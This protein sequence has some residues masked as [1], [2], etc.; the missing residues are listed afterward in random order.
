MGRGPGSRWRAA[1]G[2][3]L[4]LVLMAGCSSAG[5]PDTS[6]DEVATTT[7]ARAEAM[8]VDD[9]L[10]LLRA[11]GEQVLGSH[12]ATVEVAHVDDPDFGTMTERTTVLLDVRGESP[13]VEA[14]MEMDDGSGYP[15]MGI[16]V[17]EDATFTS[18]PLPDGEVVWVELA[19]QEADF[20]AQDMLTEGSPLLFV[21]TIWEL[22]DDD[23][24]GVE[25]V[26]AEDVDGATMDHYVVAMEESVGEQGWTGSFMP[27]AA[28]YDVWLDEE[29]LMRRVE[30]D[31]DGARLVA[32][33]DRWGEEVQVSAPDPATVVSSEE[34]ESM[35]MDDGPYGDPATVPLEIMAY[36]EQLGVCSVSVGRVEAG[37][38]PVFVMAEDPETVVELVDA[39]GDVVFSQVG[40]PFVED[41]MAAQEPAVDLEAGDYTVVCTYPGGFVGEDELSV[42]DGE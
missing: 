6:D 14:T 21:E 10:A 27:V 12:E 20:F 39:A 9:F 8:S 26:G 22:W 42:A 15:G 35:Y 30:A 5:D 28:S 41:P 31:P 24:V 40:D 17:L 33:V 29:G 34:M 36:D 11:P 4:A 37:T 1:A 2:A 3:V 19:G 13:L 7:E 25:L 18:E 23:G 38:H 16:V 32:T